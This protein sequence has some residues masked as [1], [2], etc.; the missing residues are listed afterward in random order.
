MRFVFQTQERRTRS[1]FVLAVAGICVLGCGYHL[2]TSIRLN[3]LISDLRT[4]RNFASRVSAA[5]KLGHFADP[6]ATEALVD[7]MDDPG[8]GRYAAEAMDN[9]FHEGRVRISSDRTVL[10]LV[11]YLSESDPILRGRSTLFLGFLGVRAAVPLA[12]ALRAGDRGLKLEVIEP[13]E[14]ALCE[15]DAE[16]KDLKDATDILLSTLQDA[17]ADVRRYA[18]STISSCTKSVF[19]NAIAARIEQHD[20]LVV[21]GAHRQL[22]ASGQV[23]EE[24]LIESLDSYGDDQMALDFL[25]SK[26]EKLKSAARRWISAHRI[27]LVVVPCPPSCGGIPIDSPKEKH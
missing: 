14:S 13:L 2:A 21:A 26:N 24:L 4:S 7:T 19:G 11:S 23:P 9:Q 10:K 25:G 27:E 5:S 12:N 18:A 8:V 15:P 6:R 17:D 22:M 1:V 20:L 3:R 16:T